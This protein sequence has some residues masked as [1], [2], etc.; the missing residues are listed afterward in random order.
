MDTK[1]RRTDKKWTF[2][3][4]F[5][6]KWQSDIRSV[7]KRKEMGVIFANF[8]FWQDGRLAWSYS[9]FCDSFLLTALIRLYLWFENIQ[10]TMFSNVLFLPIL[11]LPPLCWWFRFFLLSVDYESH[12]SIF[13]HNKATCVNIGTMSLFRY[14]CLLSWLKNPW[15]L[16]TYVTAPHVFYGPLLHHML[17]EK[18]KQT[19]SFVKS[20]IES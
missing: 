1:N 10:K 13:S 6:R 12:V 8:F 14:F 5:Q 18:N 7:Q 19:N 3:N 9:V 4:H 2:V 11:L 16:V 20:R 15:T 17:R